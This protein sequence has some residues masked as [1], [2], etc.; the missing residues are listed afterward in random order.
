MAQSSRVCKLRL[1]NICKDSLENER[2]KVAQSA[3]HLCSEYECYTAARA[4]LLEQIKL[5][6]KGSVETIASAA[7]AGVVALHLVTTLFFG[8]GAI[9]LQ[10]QSVNLLR[11]TKSEQEWIQLCMTAMMEWLQQLWTRSH[12]YIIGKCVCFLCCGKSV[13]TDSLIGL[14]TPLSSAMNSRNGSNGVM[15]VDNSLPA[16]VHALPYQHPV[17]CFFLNAFVRLRERT[18]IQASS[19][20]RSCLCLLQNILMVEP[21]AM[22]QKWCMQR[23]M[24]LLLE[25]TGSVHELAVL[26]RRSCVLSDNDACQRIRDAGLRSWSDVIQRYHV[27]RAVDNKHPIQAARMERDIY[28]LSAY[29]HRAFPVLPTT[30]TLAMVLTGAACGTDNE[31][32][33]VVAVENTVCDTTMTQASELVQS[34]TV[35]SGG[36]NNGVVVFNSRIGV[37][38]AGLVTTTITR[39]RGRDESHE[40]ADIV[41]IGIDLQRTLLPRHQGRGNGGDA[42]GTSVHA[43]TAT[44]VRRLYLAATTVLEQLLICIFFTTALRIGGVRRIRR[45]HVATWDESAER[46]VSKMHGVTM[47][48]GGHFHTFALTLRC[49]LLL[50]EWLNLP[51]TPRFAAYVFTEHAHGTRKHCV[52]HAS[53]AADMDQRMAPYQKEGDGC[54]DAAS[55]RHIFRRVA[56]AAGLC[57]AHVH[58]HTCRHTVAVCLNLLGNR[59]EHI[60]EFLG[61]IDLD[62][63]ARVYA[64]LTAQQRE[65]RMIIPWLDR[66]HLLTHRLQEAVEL[67][68]ALAGPVVVA[69]ELNRVDFLDTATLLQLVRRQQLELGGGGGGARRDRKQFAADPAFKCLRDA[70]RNRERGLLITYD[71]I[72]RLIDFAPV[73]ATQNN[74]P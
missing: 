26:D 25:S 71:R 60:A 63:T 50:E 3:S 13:P 16:E 9:P 12:A 58:P 20:M 67:A 62:V 42:A 64:R 17:R 7:S 55:L 52:T 34:E 23:E 61:N 28:W 2:A 39:K 57:G 56:K 45:C 21:V 73:T 54:A 41:R 24:K 31:E 36:G 40:K 66:P 8:H 69:N 68:S 27:H 1:S 22:P 30:M 19:T 43:F 29:F 14:Q 74:P 5:G 4:S 70:V 72:D 15:T 38:A 33:T 47:E 48:K 49:R 59:M 44:E 11:A 35:V 46:W 37:N 65:Q 32:C 6:D 51:D 10:W 18:Q 53:C